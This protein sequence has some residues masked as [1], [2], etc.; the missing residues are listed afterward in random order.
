MS[1]TRA[2]IEVE[3]VQTGLRIESKILKVLKG[4][5]EYKDLGTNE[6][7]E[8]ILMHAF[9]NRPCFSAD[10]FQAVKDLKKIYGLSYDVHDYQAFL[11]ISESTAGEKKKS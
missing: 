6:M 5:A 8:L 7:L 10:G 4:M 3:R 11:E 9:E 2:K 1:K